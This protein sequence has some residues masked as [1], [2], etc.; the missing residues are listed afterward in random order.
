M[1]YGHDN[2]IGEYEA[3]TDTIFTVDE[4]SYEFTV[5]IEWRSDY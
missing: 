2:Y 5:I 3:S 1:Y 4:V